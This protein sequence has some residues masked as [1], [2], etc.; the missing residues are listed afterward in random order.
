MNSHLKVNIKYINL[1]ERSQSLRSIG[2]AQKRIINQVVENAKEGKIGVRWCS[3]EHASG[4][5][6]L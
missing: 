2:H 5:A 3:F 4:S 6:A 1:N